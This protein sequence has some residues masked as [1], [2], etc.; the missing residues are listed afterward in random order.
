MAIKKTPKQ[1]AMAL[2]DSL[3]DEKDTGK[4]NRKI[5]NFIKILKKNNDLGLIDKIIIEFE[6]IWKKENGVMGVIV[7]SAR[8]LEQKEKDNLSGKLLKYCSLNIDK[9]IKK[10]EI[11]E[12]VDENLLGGVFLKINDLIIDNTIRGQLKKLKEKIA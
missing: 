8:P 9:N 10:I 2:Y 11:K 6:A 1:Y 7:K 4:I 12:I 5:L 3:R